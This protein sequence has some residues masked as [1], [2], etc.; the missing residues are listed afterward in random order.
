[1]ATAR[2]GFQHSDHAEPHRSRT[3][4]IAKAHPE[5]RELNGKNAWT[6]VPTAFL[7][8]IQLAAA[9]WI[10][11]KPWWVFLLVAYTLGA[12]V[13]HALLVVIHES[14]HNLIFKR[15][16]SNVLTGI[17]ANIPGVLP[18]SATFKNYHLVHHWHQGEYHLDADIPN[19]WEARVVGTSPIRKII[20]LALFPILSMTRIM[21][22]KEVR[23]I[24]RYVVLNWSIV[25]TTNVLIWF[26]A[27]PTAV[28]YLLVS[29][30]FSAGIHPVGAR[31]IQRHYLMEQGSDQ[32]TF[33]YYGPMNVFAFNVGY[34]NEHHD[35]PRV[36]W[37]KLPK[38][39]EAAPE[40]YEDLLAH[41]SW[42]K[43][44]MKFIFD[45]NLDLFARVVRDGNEKVRPTED[46][47]KSEVYEGLAPDTP[48]DRSHQPAAATVD[49]VPEA[50]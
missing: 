8:A 34:H 16:I 15:K 28:L 22:I 48:E 50:T 49:P 12:V 14:C 45:R 10:V 46:L 33:S 30:F 4:A 44:F 2:T 20:W 37:H 35:F 17:F 38:V 29:F 43:L 26:L 25:M 3:Q 40:Y 13:N 7:V 23:K 11:G 5:I 36:P 32:E 41:Q 19:A 6:F 21:R 24:D 31:W 1:M 27:G 18:Y 47:E 39:R 42:G 9:F